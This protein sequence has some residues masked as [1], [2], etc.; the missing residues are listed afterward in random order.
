MKIIALL[1]SMLLI[2]GGGYIILPGLATYEKDKPVIGFIEFR[3]VP[4]IYTSHIDWEFIL[5]GYL[6]FY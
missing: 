3:I 2:I 5:N 4:Y 1:V 6:L